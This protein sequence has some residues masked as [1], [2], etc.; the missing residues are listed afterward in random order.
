VIF[1]ERAAEGMMNI[2]SETMDLG[3]VDFRTAPVINSIVFEYAVAL[4]GEKCGIANAIGF[5]AT[6]QRCCIHF[7]GRCGEGKKCRSAVETTIDDLPDQFVVNG[8]L[9]GK[10]MTI[11]SAISNERVREAGTI[12]RSAEQKQEQ[13]EEKEIQ[14]SSSPFGDTPVK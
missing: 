4:R 8:R 10:D 9:T 11:V 5:S 14:K 2:E 7:A 12:D 13:A 6:D 3:D 1:P